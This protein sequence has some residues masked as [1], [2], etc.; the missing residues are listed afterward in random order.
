MARHRARRRGRPRRIE[1]DDIVR[2]ALEIG[3]ERLTMR[4]VA[5]RLGVGLSSLYYHVESANELS[6][7]AGGQ[8][9]ERLVLPDL[10]PERWEETARQSARALRVA[11]ESTPGLIDRRFGDP[12]WSEVIL[13]LNELACRRFVRAGFD[14]AT[15]WLAVRLIADFV[16]GYVVRKRTHERAGSTDLEEAVRQSGRDE[17]PTLHT[18]LRQLGSHSLERR[19]EFGLD[20]LLRGLRPLRGDA[21]RR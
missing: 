17:A 1:L 3:L 7:L 21:R 11:L 10:G 8:M 9:M 6:R 5:A 14:A 2:A 4:G 13:K 12:R 16:E 18:A 19:F 20:C 15:A